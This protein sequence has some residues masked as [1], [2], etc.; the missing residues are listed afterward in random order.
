MQTTAT[1]QPQCAS[2]R[3]TCEQLR[4]Q[5]HAAALHEVLLDL[6]DRGVVQAANGADL[7][8]NLLRAFFGRVVR[9]YGD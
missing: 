7:V 9:I 2:T 5:E 3:P 1:N 6:E 4:D 8:K